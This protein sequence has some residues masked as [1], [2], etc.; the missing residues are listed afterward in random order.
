MEDLKRI[1]GRSVFVTQ[2]LRT[3]GEQAELYSKGRTAPGSIVTR[4]QPGMSWH[5]YGLAVDFA[6]SGKEP[7]PNDDALWK[8]FGRIFEAYG[9]VWGGNFRTFKDRPHVELSYGLG[10][11]EALELYYRGEVAAVWAEID[12][13][14]GVPLACEWAG[15]WEHNE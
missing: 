15:L 13:I 5:N 14:R 8:D 1:L 4:A 11:N 7:Y 12:R 6:F 10:L 2:G 3:F 9:F